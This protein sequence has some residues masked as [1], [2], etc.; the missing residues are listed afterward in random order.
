LFQWFNLP[1]ANLDGSQQWYS[2]QANG[3][4]R[5]NTF[6]VDPAITV[7]ANGAVTRLIPIPL[8]WAPMFLDG[9]NF[10]TAFRRIFDLYD[11]L[12]EDDRSDLYPI[13]EMKGMACC[14]AD[15]SNM[16]PSTLSTQWT[17]L[18]YHARTKR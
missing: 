9:P 7:K 5:K 12:D 4:D 13:V 14:T 17:R 18:T 2:S 10:G 11:S 15:T 1:S 6:L 3:N 8:E 16:A